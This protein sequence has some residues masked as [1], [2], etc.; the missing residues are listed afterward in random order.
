MNII[1]WY[2]ETMSEWI[3]SKFGSTCTNWTMINNFAISILSTNTDTWIRTL[4]VCTCFIIFT[5]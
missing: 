2:W 4:L 1:T 5:F 3:S